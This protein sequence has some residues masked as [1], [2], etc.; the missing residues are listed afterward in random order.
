[1]AFSKAIAASAAAMIMVAPIAVQAAPVDRAHSKIAERNELAGPAVYVLIAI[2][3]LAVFFAIDG[4][5]S[6]SVSN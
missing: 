1:M 3:V 5:K 6:N 4:G 2:V